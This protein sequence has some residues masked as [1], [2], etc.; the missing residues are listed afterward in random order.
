[1][2][3]IVLVTG[4]FFNSQITLETAGNYIIATMWGKHAQPI[5]ILVELN[6][7]GSIFGRNRDHSFSHH[8]HTGLTQVFWWGCSGTGA[9]RWHS[10]PSSGDVKKTPRFASTPPSLLPFSLWQRCW[11]VDR[12]KIK[13]TNHRKLKCTKIPST[14]F[15]ECLHLSQVPLLLHVLCEK[16]WS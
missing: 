13:L 16:D 7:Q 5:T 3:I 9:Y 12:G 10:T 1:M 14:L 15:K 2:T 11:R 8:V 6:D 4:D